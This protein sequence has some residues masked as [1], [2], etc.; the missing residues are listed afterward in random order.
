MIDLYRL[1]R[2]YLDR[3]FALW[4]TLRGCLFTRTQNGSKLIIDNP[5]FAM[6]LAYLDKV[7]FPFTSISVTEKE[8]KND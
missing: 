6:T 8:N 7:G 3:F 5:G 2:K 4:Y 1:N